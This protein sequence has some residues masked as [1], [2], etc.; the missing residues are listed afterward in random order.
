MKEYDGKVR[1]VLKHMVV[2]PDTVAKAHLAACAAGKQGKFV[3]FYKTFWEKSFKPYA[4]SRG[5]NRDALAEST[6]MTWAKDLGIDTAK[7]KTDMEGQECNQ[8]VQ[9]DMAELSKFRVSGTPAFFINGQFI[10]GGIPKEAF[11]Q[12]IDEKLKEVDASGVPPTEY[13][14]KVIMAKGE[15]KFRSR[16]QGAGGAPP[17]EQPGHEGHGH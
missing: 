15:K 12:I 16:K 11:K 3:P 10:G 9:A 8:F 14:E 13:Y 2:H 7:L 4:E 6:F 1:V 17:A 5:Q